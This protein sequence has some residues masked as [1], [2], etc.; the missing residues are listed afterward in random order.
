MSEKKEDSE[1]SIS[2]DLDTTPA[3][4]EERSSVYMGGKLQC[5]VEAPNL[6][7]KADIVDLSIL[8][9]AIIIPIESTGGRPHPKSADRLTLKFEE[10]KDLRAFQ[11]DAEIRNVEEVTYQKYKFLRLGL[12]HLVNAYKDQG[13]FYSATRRAM[14]PCHPY[15][16]P[17]VTYRDPF[18]F[19]ER[20]ICYVNAFSYDGMEVIWPARAKTIFPNQVIDLHV[21]IP[22]QSSYKIWTES[23]N[24]FYHVN[25]ESISRYHRYKS[26]D[27]LYL[28]L[29][30]Q[31]LIYF[32]KMMSPTQLRNGYFKVGSLLSCFIIQYSKPEEDIVKKRKLAPSHFARPFNSHN[33]T[34]PF[35]ARPVSC[36]VGEHFAAIFGVLF[37]D[38]KKEKSFLSSSGHKLS[39]T[40]MS[41]GH[42]EIVELFISN[43]VTAA[44]CFLPILQQTV[45][46][47]ALAS[48]K[49]VCFEASI[50]LGPALKK[51][52][53][54]ETSST[55]I[56]D[57]ENKSSP[58]M[59]FELDLQRVNMGNEKFLPD[60]VW[61]GLYAE[62]SSVFNVV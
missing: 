39:E 40:V 6:Q 34:L 56:K 20:V 4:Q 10:Q 28:E 41:D 11:F 44:D 25:E 8:G 33:F 3:R 53:F 57:A 1:F 2:L 23:T 7:G 42:I 26:P 48:I 58:S 13:S 22:G 35:G 9:L 27:P 5:L 12:K 60:A 43:I 62:L 16:R 19:Q 52:G 14:V 55:M 51:F 17:Q 50:K 49:Y 24:L 46:I 61:N 45:R 38:K 30:S 47:A 29:V 31:Y 37:V 54:I 32:Q 59:L 21:F 18:N 36:F 15:I